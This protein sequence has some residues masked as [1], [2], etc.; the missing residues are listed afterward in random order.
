VVPLVIFEGVTEALQLGDNASQW[1]VV[2]GIERVSTRHVFRPD[3]RLGLQL[4][5]VSHL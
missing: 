4:S 3:Y 2:I 1:I 5:T